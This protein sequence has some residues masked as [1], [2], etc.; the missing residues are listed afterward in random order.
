MS[1]YTPITPQAAFT[2]AQHAA[3]TSNMLLV[4]R[5]MLL[6]R[7]TSCAGVNA[8]LGV[9]GV[10]VDILYPCIISWPRSI[11]VPGILVHDTTRL[12]RQW[13]VCTHRHAA[14]SSRAQVNLPLNCCSNS[15]TIKLTCFSACQTA[16][17]HVF[18]TLS[19]PHFPLAVFQRPRHETRRLVPVIGIHWRSTG[20]TGDQQTVWMT[21][22]FADRSRWL[23]SDGCCF[24]SQGWLT[25]VYNVHIL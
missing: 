12:H 20:P 19:F 6:V 24:M 1:T 23:R 15:L 7:A 16:T 25:G 11:S 2:P 13:R 8:A 3:R 14:I 4:A 10:Y 22:D 18:Y 5:N 9:I 21:N 17:L